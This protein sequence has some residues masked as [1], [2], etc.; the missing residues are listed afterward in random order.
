MALLSISC[1]VTCPETLNIT[2]RQ[3][4]EI[5]DNAFMMYFFEQS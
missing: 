4:T 1:G 3:K 2:A 5:I